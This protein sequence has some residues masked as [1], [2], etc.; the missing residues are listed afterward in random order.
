MRHILSVLANREAWRVL[1][2]LFR[3]QEHEAR[4]EKGRRDWPLRNRNA[5]RDPPKELHE[6]VLKTADILH[7]IE[8]IIE[9][10][11]S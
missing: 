1:T 2:L 6:S 11:G 5:A 4:E 8:M 10:A 3:A 9:S 7:A